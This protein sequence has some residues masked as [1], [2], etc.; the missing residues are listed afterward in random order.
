MTAMALIDVDKAAKDAVDEAGLKIVPLLEPIL[1]AA[2]LKLTGELKTLLVGRKI[3][4]TI[5]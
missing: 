1:T 2:V 5:E 3:T 4:I